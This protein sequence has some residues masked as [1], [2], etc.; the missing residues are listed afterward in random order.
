MTYEL[1]AYQYVM[2]KLFSPVF[3]LTLVDGRKPASLHSIFHIPRLVN[4]LRNL[5]LSV[6]PGARK[7]LSSL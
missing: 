7:S 6:S 1:I 4:Y 2:L 5:S 3:S